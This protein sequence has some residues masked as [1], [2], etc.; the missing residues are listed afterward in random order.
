VPEFLDLTLLAF[1]LI[2]ALTYCIVVENILLMLATVAK[3]HAL[4]ADAGFTIRVDI[5]FLAACLLDVAGALPS[6]QALVIAIFTGAFGV[7][8]AILTFHQTG[9]ILRT[10]LVEESLVTLV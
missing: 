8:V 3:Q 4:C 6:E 9:N 1:A 2:I 5:A 7:G 10:R